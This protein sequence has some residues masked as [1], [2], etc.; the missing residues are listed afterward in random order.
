MSSESTDTRARVRELAGSNELIY[1]LETVQI[2]ISNFVSQ[3]FSRY[4][5]YCKKKT[6]FNQSNP[7]RKK[8]F[9][10][11]FIENFLCNFFKKKR[12][13]HTFKK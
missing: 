7:F 5:D 9:L 8:L 11:F 10:I 6:F 4:D 13:A 3:Q 12:L 1:I 2:A